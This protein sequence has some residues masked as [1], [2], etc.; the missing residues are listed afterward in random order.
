MRIMN[1]LPALNAF[2]ALNSTN[3]SLQKTINSLSTGLRINSSSDDAAGFA[4][5]GR[6][7]AQVGGLDTAL[8]NSQDGMSLL[9]TAEGALSQTNDML[10]RMRDLSVQAGSDSLTSQDRQYIQQEIDQLKD[11]IDRIADTTQFNRKRILDG[12]SGALWVSSDAG[13][14]VR[15]NGG[16]TYTDKNGQKVSAEGNYRI[17]IAA[18]PGQSQVQKSNIMLIKHKN[19]AMDRTVNRD[20][21]INGVSVD[22]LPAGNYR[23]ASEL[24]NDARAI[25]TG[26]YGM[27]FTELDGALTASVKNST[28]T[29][30][31]SILF[32]VTRVDYD[33]GSITVNA[34]ANVLHTDGTTETYNQSGIVLSEGKFEDLSEILGV[35]AAGTDDSAA[36]G[37]FELR[38]E[39]YSAGAF[40]AGDKF[41]YN[42]NTAKNISGTDRVIK[43]TNEQNTSWSDYWQ[44]TEE[45]YRTAPFQPSDPADPKARVLFLIDD[46]GSMSTT[47]RTVGNNISAF[48]NNIKAEGVDDIDVAVAS[49]ASHY[50]VDPVTG[51]PDYSSLA[52]KLIQHDVGGA[53]WSSDISDV[54]AALTALSGQCNGG[55]V[56]P[57]SAIC[58]AVNQYS[59]NPTTD[60]TYI[61]LV[62]DT[63]HETSSGGYTLSDAQNALS[64]SGTTLVAVTPSR[65]SSIYS[66]LLSGQRYS[67]NQSSPSWG[68][69]LSTTLASTIG[70]DVVNSKLFADTQLYEFAAFSSVFP[71]A[72][73]PS[74][75]L[76]ITV[77]GVPHDVEVKPDDTMK[78]L[79]ENIDAATGGATNA[80]FVDDPESGERGIIL[81]TSIGPEG[82]IKFSGNEQLINALGLRSNLE[83]K[84]SLDASEVTNRDIHFRNFYLNSE[85]GQA[86]SGDIILTT[87]STEIPEY[88][89]LAG[90]EAAYIGQVP[91]N[92]VSLRDINNFWNTEGG[93][94]VE[95]PKTITVTQGNGKTASVTFYDTD[96]LDDVREKLNNAIGKGLGQSAYAD[97]DKFVSYVREGTELPQGDESVAG[98]FIIRSA[99]P[100]KDGELY[101]SGDEDLLNA[102]GLNTIHESSESR[103]TAS[104]YDA[105]SGAKINTMTADSGEFKSIIPPDIDIDI[106]PMTTA[107]SA[108][109]DE[110]TKRFMFA[111]NQGYT[112]MLHLKDNGI[113]FQTGAN[114]GEE[115]SIQI[116]DMSSQALGVSRVVVATRE[117]AAKSIGIIDRAISKVSAQRSKI[118]S[119]IN[120]LEHTMTNLTTT[121]ANITAADSRLRDADMALTMM[122][123]V[124]LQILNQSGTSMLAQA[125]QR[126][127]SILNL[128]GN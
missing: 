100:G 15:I 63:G 27:S 35:G 72:T 103:Y 37:A 20:A 122:D 16:L 79:A 81:S 68:K 14:R 39:S 34:S 9:Q 75:T 114:T 88:N 54:E 60:K 11:Q 56:D 109:W 101:F 116:G 76:T 86:S 57:Y 24:P 104:V 93:C 40:E 78:T 45:I 50:D 126:P 19:V 28:L 47:I 70:E 115:F 99:V 25:A 21:S 62:T 26:I 82:G 128:L 52:H 113:T 29:A 5:S 66:P 127:Q 3:R 102:L 83:T 13:V 97:A 94:I 49:Y 96:T 44:E 31:A 1:N 84:Y 41:V 111:H 65:Y 2:R 59:L 42:L 67:I 43:F 46:S 77:D 10:Q 12:S 112:A 98:T 85:T 120:G 61:V 89:L 73:S 92:D 7:R 125:N 90:F 107:I 48:L 36:D 91:K 95:Q 53:D 108:K 80:R 106:D 123:F 71:S 17:E 118:G 38:L 55:A 117:S 87:N 121:S 8:R 110:N 64:N 119:Y 51:L 69:T 23:A 22:N 58:E 74:I 105:H 124:R 18:T 33:S 4:I 6:L 30:N 32:E